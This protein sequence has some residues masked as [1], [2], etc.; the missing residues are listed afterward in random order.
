MGSKHLHLVGERE[1]KALGVVGFDEKPKD[2]GGV[3]GCE[4]NRRASECLRPVV[5]GSSW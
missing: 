3:G 4:G 2:E 5:G 1:E